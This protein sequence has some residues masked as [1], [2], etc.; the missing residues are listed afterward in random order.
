[1]RQDLRFALVSA[2]GCGAVVQQRGLCSAILPFHR[3]FSRLNGLEGSPPPSHCRICLLLPVSV[4]GVRLSTPQVRNG[5]Q[6]PVIAAWSGPVEV[7]QPNQPMQGHLTLTATPGWVGGVGADG[8]GWGGVVRL[9]VRR[10]RLGGVWGSGL[11]LPEV[12]CSHSRRPPP[13]AFA[14]ESAGAGR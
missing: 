11:C 5:L 14:I 2:G 7:E 8:V 4:P 9:V 1:M 12:P 3:A 10:R 13:D 6:F